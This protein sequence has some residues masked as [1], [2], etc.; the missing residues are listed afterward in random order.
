MKRDNIAVN[1]EANILKI[2]R[3]VRYVKA[4]LIFLK[5]KNLKFCTILNAT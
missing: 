2:F 4:S 1:N 5:I 3:L